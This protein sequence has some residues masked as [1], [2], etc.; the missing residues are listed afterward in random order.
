MHDR[1]PPALAWLVKRRRNIAGRIAEAKNRYAVAE[2]EYR[3]RLKP[4]EILIAALEKDLAAVDQTIRLHEI[5]IDPEALGGTR[6]QHSPRR[7]GYAHMTRSIYT[8]LGSAFPNA[9]DTDQLTARFIADTPSVV[10]ETFVQVRLKVRRRLRTLVAAGMVQ[11]L[12]APY[13]GAKTLGIWMLA[14]TPETRA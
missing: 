6:A 9:L 3:E 7:H 10:F 1:V 2:V 14:N 11:R 8:H 5:P 13:S 12:H 4:V